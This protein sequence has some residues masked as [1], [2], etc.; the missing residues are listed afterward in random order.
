MPLI[1]SASKEAIGHNIKVEEESGKPK[2]QAVAIGLNVAREAGAH[3]PKPK[4]SH[5]SH[6]HKEHR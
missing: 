2:K 6:R 5:S 3:I 1:K 4:E